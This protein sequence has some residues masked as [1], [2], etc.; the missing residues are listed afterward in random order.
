MG[1]AM[2]VHASGVADAKAVEAGPSHVRLLA[3]NGCPYRKSNPDV[4][5]M[6]SPE[7]RQS[8]DPPGCLDS[9]SARSVL[10]K[11]QMRARSGR[12]KRTAIVHTPILRPS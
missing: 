11:R 12:P 8:L 1:E 5:V 3:I 9:S 10:G 2:T 4:L 6:Q 7:D